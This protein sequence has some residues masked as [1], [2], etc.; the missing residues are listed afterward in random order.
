MQNFASNLFEMTNDAENDMTVIE[1]ALYSVKSSFS[2]PS[3][4]SAEQGQL[5]YDT[6]RSLLRHRGATNNWRG[7]IA[8]SASFKIWV[9]ANAAEEGFD[10]DVTHGDRV[11]ALRG[12]SAAYSAWGDQSG[13]QITNL[14]SGYESSHYHSHTHLWFKFIGGNNDD[15]IYDASG[16]PISPS[17]VPRDAS[18][19]KYSVHGDGSYPD[20]GGYDMASFGADRGTDIDSTPATTAHNH[21]VTHTPGWRPQ[22][23][24]G[25]MVYPKAVLQ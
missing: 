25:I 9:Y 7:V 21:T 1:N 13:W 12:G 24:V 10:E 14:S 3:A 20:N 18:Y 6:T 22:A 2:G 15:K 17:S 23:A 16:N 4:P 19:G 11:I 8:G 5:W